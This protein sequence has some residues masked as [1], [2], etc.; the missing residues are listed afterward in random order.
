MPEITLSQGSRQGTDEDPF[1]RGGVQIRVKD[2]PLEEM[3]QP[4]V[5]WTLTDDP[6]WTYPWDDST[7]PGSRGW[8]VIGTD[9]RAI[10]YQG[11]TIGYE[12]QVN[13]L[14]F[15]E[16][17]RTTNPYYKRRDPV[18]MH[19][20]FKM[21]TIEIRG[22]ARM[23]PHKT[24]NDVPIETL[25]CSDREILISI[26]QR[27][28]AIQ[29]GDAQR[30]AYRLYQ[31][32]LSSAQF[33]REYPFYEPKDEPEPSPGPAPEPPPP[34]PSEGKTV[35]CADG[36]L[37][38]SAAAFKAA[39]EAGDLE[40][41]ANPIAGYSEWRSG[42]TRAEF[43]ERYPS[44]FPE[45]R[46]EQENTTPPA[47]RLLEL[48]TERL[49]LRADNYWGGIVTSC[50]RKHGQVWVETMNDVNDGGRDG[51]VSLA[52]GT[53]TPHWANDPLDDDPTF[54]RRFNP[55]QGGSLWVNFREGGKPVKRP[56]F[57]PLFYEVGANF[58]RVIT[59]MC[60]YGGVLEP[61]RDPFEARPRWTL[62]Y[63]D[64]QV[65]LVA[66]DFV[67]IGFEIF[68][69]YEEPQRIGEYDLSWYLTPDYYHRVNRPDGGPGQFEADHVVIYGEY[70]ENTAFW[71]PPRYGRKY[72]ALWG[73]GR[74]GD[75]NNLQ[76]TSNRPPEEMR[77]Y[78]LFL[79]ARYHPN[80][81]L[82][83]YERISGEGMVA[84]NGDVETAKAILAG[85]YVPPEPPPPPAPSDVDTRRW[86][87]LGGT[88]ARVLD[89]ADIYPA[90]ETM[91]ILIEEMD[92]PSID[93]LEE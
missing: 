43:Q 65:E 71:V 26:N 91:K 53:L 84:Y 17:F 10:D 78:H 4:G 36:T 76:T 51:Q 13:L 33:V 14:W 48:H 55:T 3:C 15:N 60:D 92:D 67:Q 20:Q 49:R 42:L 41:F 32:S 29:N 93:K 52:D 54:L 27:Q 72:I 47:Q 88:I 35:H 81:M 34:E 73:C 45:P 86:K 39:Q 16:L 37:K 28:A 38:I 57:Y 44:Y 75:V 8:A 56:I 40:E 66:T 68:H 61:T 89:E 9:G 79:G 85:E 70:G 12:G 6:N 18:W 31:T 19:V 23:I 83:P 11:G 21:K 46:I 82:Q 90:T 77:P 22:R 25:R 1:L 24:T 69:K 50:L 5:Q 63:V 80:R 74:D 62:W 7:P 87:A 59:Q 58:Y 30:V 2:I 64:W